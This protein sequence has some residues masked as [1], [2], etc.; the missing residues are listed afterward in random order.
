MSLD[1]TKK[2]SLFSAIA[3][4]A[5]GM[6]GSGWL[7]SAQLNA[8]LAGNYSFL[9]WIAA[10]ALALGVGLCLAQV[11]ALYPV[12]G[13]TTRIAALSHNN[14]FGMPFAFAAWFG[15]MA[16]VA[17]EAQATTQYLAAVLPQLNLLNAAGLTLWGKLF[18]LVILGGYLLV[19]YYGIQML[20]QVNNLVTLL[21]L[22][23]PVLTIIVFI[24]AY[25]DTSNFN[26]PNH[27]GAGTVISSLV[28]A[29]LVYSFN[30]FQISVA[31][32]SELQN[33]RRNIPLALIISISCVLLLYLF[34]QAAFMGA[35]PHALLS[36]G[37]WANLNFQSPLINLAMLLGFNF[38]TILLLADSVLSPSGTGFTYLG[39]SARMMYAMAAEGQMPRWTIAPLHPIYFLCRRSLLINWALTTM[40]LW[41][42][43]S[44]AALMVIVTGYNL[45]GYM[46]APIAMGALTPRYRI[47]GGLVFIILGLVL[48]TL[49]AHDFYIMNFSIM[50]V[51][52][53]FILLQLRNQPLVGLLLTSFPLLSYLWLILFFPQPLVVVILSG[54]IYLG[55]TSK[56]FVR[57]CVKNKQESLNLEEDM[58]SGIKHYI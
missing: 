34:L 25:F 11:V 31:F 53:I 40:V 4:S 6:V 22:C 23:A 10:A 20:A 29:G 38:L 51:M 15:L 16:M 49:T 48:S 35:V 42:S 43:E 8:K 47:L 54:L 30:G 37:G 21:K 1:T 32:A 27:Y 41:N 13:A 7:F 12:R 17:T 18:A 24:I 33:P 55:V 14:V 2:G 46:A 36:G 39:S 44:W 9:A 5:T 19:N 52:G 58:A 57:F 50:I 56:L 26:L 45:I 28:G 3:L